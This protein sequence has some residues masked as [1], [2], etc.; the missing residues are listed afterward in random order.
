MPLSLMSRTK[1]VAVVALARVTIHY[2]R[3]HRH[4]LLFVIIVLVHSCPPP[5]NCPPPVLSDGPTRVTAG[6]SASWVPQPKPSAL[7]P[8]LPL[9]RHRL[10]SQG[11]RPHR[12]RRTTLRRVRGRSALTFHRLLS[13]LTPM[14]METASER[15]FL[16][17]IFPVVSDRYSIQYF[18]LTISSSLFPPLS[19]QFSH[20]SIHIHILV[21]ARCFSQF[22]CVYRIRLIRRYLP[23]RTSHCIVARDLTFT[24]FV[25]RISYS[26]AYAASLS[27]IISFIIL[28]QH[29]V[30]LS[31]LAPHPS[32]AS[33]YGA[34]AGC[35]LSQCD[36]KHLPHLH[37]LRR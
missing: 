19:H 27:S 8:L 4:H 5:E 14:E 10:L 32:S 3:T 1:R 18:L 11:V 37:F 22:A 17:V 26:T 15:S 29:N 13:I 23:P 9:C 20:I 30:P 25:R 34:F 21:T 2:L 12:T 36:H 7:F 33:A 16:P 31:V 24:Q 35:V 6:L 28:S